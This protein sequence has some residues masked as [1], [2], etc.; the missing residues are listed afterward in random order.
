M[1]VGGDFNAGAVGYRT[2]RIWIV[3]ERGAAT[4]SNQQK[5]YTGKANHHFA[6]FVANIEEPLAFEGGKRCCL[7]MPVEI[8]AG[9]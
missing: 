8:V 4:C 7:R 2:R 6:T 3:R 9:N 5:D 1:V